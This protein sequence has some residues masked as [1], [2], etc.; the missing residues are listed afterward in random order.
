MG[1]GTRMVT[2]GLEAENGYK[3]QRT[4]HW[5]TG[6]GS[7]LHELGERKDSRGTALLSYL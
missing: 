3:R 2:V 1:T 5:A 7:Q 6:L 4:R